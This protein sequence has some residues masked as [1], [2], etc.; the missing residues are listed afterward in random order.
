MHLKK[1]SRTSALVAAA[2]ISTAAVAD[3]KV[4]GF[5]EW[6][7]LDAGG[8]FKST[9]GSLTALTFSGSGDMDNGIGYSVSYDIEDGDAAGHNITFDLGSGLKLGIGYDQAYG[10]E[11]VKAISPYVN[12]R[13]ADIT[14]AHRGL[15]T[16]ARKPLGPDVWDTSSGENALGL[17]FKNDLAAISF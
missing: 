1:L 8:S 7:Y 5:Q 16:A 13:R 15:P 11:T 12:N 9:L 3:V 4:S 14:G 10:I 17:S 2:S 6:N